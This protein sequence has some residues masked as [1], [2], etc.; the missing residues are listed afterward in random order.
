MP[1][2]PR[3]RAVGDRPVAARPQP[4]ARR[5]PGGRGRAFRS[6]SCSTSSSDR[7]P[8]SA[9]SSA[10][11]LRQLSQETADGVTKRSAGHAEAAVH[12]RPAARSAGADRAAR[13][14][15]SS[16]TTFDAGARRRAV[17]RRATTS[18]RTSPTSIATRCSPFDRDTPRLHRPPARSARCWSK[19]FRELAPAKRAISV[20]EATLDGRRTY[21]H[22]QLRFTFP[23]RDRMTSFVAL[24]GRRRA[25]ARDVHSRARRRASW[26]R[27]K[28]PTGFR[29]CN[30]T[31]LDGDS[32]VIFPA[33]GAAPARFVDERTFPLVFFEPELQRFTAPEGR[34]PRTVAACAPATATR[35]FPTIIAARARPQRADDGGARR[36]SW[37][38][39]CFSSRARRRAKCG[40]AELKSNFVS[41]VSHDLKTPL[42]LIQLFAETLEL[43]RL[44]NTDR[45][46]EYY[47]IINSEARKLTRLINNLLDF[48][49]IEAG[50]RSYR[51][52]PVD[53]GDADPA[54]CSS[55]SRAS[56]ATTSSR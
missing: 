44:K 29:R 23:S 18:G 34:R 24:R 43:G 17:R 38:S 9:S 16:R 14:R 40:V 32:R 4:P 19:R 11:V 35:R 53:L 52:E 10:V 47:R 55:R 41:S 5:R 2:G 49:K 21:F 27:S 25:P 30:V 1:V 31:V 36:R 50:L 6:R 7:S 51:R 26:R 37:R 3:R 8:I 46:Q 20:F 42:A 13:S 22:A 39:A 45:A 33:G 12:Q 28:G 48:S 15:R 56:S 54:A